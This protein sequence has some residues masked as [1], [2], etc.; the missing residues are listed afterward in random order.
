M[1]RVGNDFYI[2]R[3]ENL[4]LDCEITNYAG[5]PLMLP[6]AWR[7]PY[8][9]ITVTS[10]DYTQAGAM[11][12]NHWL[13]IDKHWVEQDNGEEVG[14]PKLIPTKRFT[15]TEAL[16]LGQYA[17]IDDGITDA[18]VLYGIPEGRIVLN[19]ES[20]FDITNFLFVCKDTDGNPVYKYVTDYE[21]D[22]ETDT[23]SKQEWERYV[24][25]IIKSFDTKD[26]VE[27]TYHMDIK[28]LAGTSLQE[29][30][31]KALINQGYKGEFVDGDWSKEQIQSYIY[32]ILNKDQRSYA[33]ETL[34]ANLPLI[35][36]DTKVV[37]QDN[38]RIYVGVDTLGG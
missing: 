33:Q 36:Y 28:L 5:D 26:W 14:K 11:R 1:K 20:D 34:D 13:S 35:N 19:K 32:K 23:F 4:T 8:L 10:A 9:V 38:M 24:F 22:K 18:M 16:P 37:I 3:G 29:Y 2:Q 17:S 12:E 25:R 15:S 21:Y 31:T 7:N 6:R 27:Q 30:V